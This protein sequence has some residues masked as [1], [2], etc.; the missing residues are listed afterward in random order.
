[1]SLLGSRFAG[2]LNRSACPSVCLPVC[3]RSI[4]RCISS[5][6]LAKS[7]PYLTHKVPLGKYARVCSDLKQ[8]FKVI[9]ECQSRCLQNPVFDHFFFCLVLLRF[10]PKMPHGKGCYTF[11]YRST[12]EQ[13]PFKCLNLFSVI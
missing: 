13:N 11:C 5:L 10:N 7:G 3:P 4:V 2:E 6:P 8:T 1:M 9:C 12:L